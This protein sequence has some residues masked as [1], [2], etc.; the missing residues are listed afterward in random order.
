MNRN[1]HLKASTP[2][3]A[4]LAVVNRHTFTGPRDESYVYIGRG[5]PLGNNWSHVPETDAQFRVGSREEAVGRYRQWLWQEMQ[6]G[7]GPAFKA[8]ETLKERAVAG[9]KLSLACS[10]SPQLCHGDV[11]KAAIEH[12]A[13]RDREQSLRQESPSQTIFVSGSRSIKHLPAQVRDHLDRHITANSHI[14]VGDAH[15]AD[16]L[17]QQYLANAGY[18]RVT[19]FH[20][21]A[22]PRNN[23]GFQTQQVAGTRQT[24]K[25]TYMATHANRGLA[26]WDGR[27][28]GTEKN[29]GRLDT[30]VIK[31]SSPTSIR[32]EQARADI[33]ARDGQE[34]FRTIYNVPEGST[35]G[36][37]TSNLHHQDLFARDEFEHG[38]TISDSILSIPRDPDSRTHDGSN[39]RIGS[40]SHAINFVS[41]FVKDPEEARAKGER[42]YQLAERACGQ[43]TESHSRWQTF[44][45]IYDLVRKDESF[46]KGD[47]NGQYR[48]NEEKAEAINQV[49]DSIALWSNQ[50]PEPIPEPTPEEIHQYTLDLAVENKNAT[51]QPEAD[52]RIQLDTA[53]EHDP[54]LLYLH[55]LGSDSHGLATLA[56][57]T[58]FNF[59]GPQ[60]EPLVDENQVYTDV[61]ESAVFDAI[62]FSDSDHL[63]SERLS[64]GPALDA[65]FDRINLDSLPPAIPDTLSEQTEAFLLDSLIPAVDAQ[66]E[67]GFSRQE[68]LSTIYETNREIERE[69]FNDRLVNAFQVSPDAANNRQPPS[70]ED[71]L[72]A[73][74][75]LRLLVAGEYKRE[76]RGFTRD[77]IEFAKA[78]YRLDP[79][80]LRAAG[81]LKLGEYDKLINDQAAARIHWQQEHQGQPLPYRAQIARISQLEL[82][83][84]KINNRISALDPSR[85]ELVQALNCAQSNLLT[86]EQ[87]TEARLSAFSN[88]EEQQAQLSEQ[89][90]IFAQDVRSS[91]SF[92]TAQ[93][94]AAHNDH[95]RAIDEQQSVNRGNNPR[96]AYLATGRDIVT[97]EGYADLT[98]NRNNSHFGELKGEH[99]REQRAERQQL[100]KELINPDIEATQASINNE[101]AEHRHYFTQIAGREIT[102]SVEARQG[103]QPVL[104]S[105]SSVI[106]FAD[107]SR[108]RL[109]S[110]APAETNIGLDHAPIYVSLTSNENLRIPITTLPEYDALTNAVHDCRLE[111]ST[112]RTLHSPAPITG[113]D[114]EREALTTFIA[115]YIDFRQRDHVTSQL[116]RNPVFREYSQRLTDA[117]TPEELVETIALLTKENYAANQ[118]AQAHRAD[119]STPAPDKAP[120]TAKEVRELVLS[121]TPA[122]A[123]KSTRTAMREILLSTVLGKEKTDRVQ[124]LAAGKLEPS[125]GLSKLLENLESRNTE[126]ALRHFY[127]SL[128]NPNPARE[129]KFNLYEVHRL[130]P[131]FE[132]DYLYQHALAA[133][134][135]SLNGQNRSVT[136]QPEQL[137][138]DDKAISPVLV[139][140]ETN[141]YR[142][143]YG[144][145]DLREA[146]LCA[147]AVAHQRYL[148]ATKLDQSTI[149]PGFSDLEVRTVSYAVHNFDATRVS[150][151][152]VHLQASDDPHQHAL[153]DLLSLATNVN[154]TGAAQEITSEDIQLPDNYSIPTTSVISAVNFVQRDTTTLSQSTASELRQAAQKDTWKDLQ[155]SAVPDPSLLPDAPA[156]ALVQISELQ[157]TLSKAGQLQERA[158]TAFAVR[159]SH[160]NSCLERATAALRGAT[161]TST[162][163]RLPFTDPAN[164]ETTREL[165]SLALDPTR[166]DSKQLIKDHAKSFVVIQQAL[167]SGDLEKASQLSA[168]ASQARD[169]YLNVFSQIDSASNT[170]SATQHELAQNLS[171]VYELANKEFSGGAQQ[172]YTAVKENIERTVIGEQL[173]ISLANGQEIASS[174][175]SQSSVRDLLPSEIIAQATA[176]ARELAWQSFEPQ[177][178][179]DAAAGQTVDDRA[180]NLA[181]TV[182][183]HVESARSHENTLLATQEKLVTFIDERAIE[184]EDRLRTQSLTNGQ[185][186]QDRQAAERDP[187]DGPDTPPT[188]LDQTVSDQK[189]PNNPELA[190]KTQ[191]VGEQALYAQASDRDQ[192]RQQTISELKGTDSARYESLKEEVARAES[193]LTEAFLQIDATISQLELT[194]TELRVEQEIGQYRQIA[195]PVAERVNNYLKET[196][197]EEGLKSLLEPLRHEDHVER[198][199]LT[200]LQTA[201]DFN[202]PLNSSVESLQQVHEIANNLFDT[203][204]DGLERANHHLIPGMQ[205]TAETHKSEMLIGQTHRHGHQQIP[206]QNGNG[207]HPSQ[208]AAV[209]DNTHAHERILDLREMSGLSNDPL[210]DN[211]FI[212]Q[213]LTSNSPTHNL[214]Q[215]NL[216]NSSSQSNSPNSI[217]SEHDTQDLE[218]VR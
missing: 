179:R 99:E 131:Q 105:L 43:W 28:P 166:P 168:Y 24:D 44:T 7:N 138:L 165:V 126:P 162:D 31:V 182:M 148:S 158:R 11:I 175:G 103:L 156:S 80:Q 215:L 154:S 56:E 195:N 86:A 109:D 187:I 132:R 52:E 91:E 171:T 14:L 111:T 150:Q 176:E 16:S 144:Q 21:G 149:A 107:R 169:Q 130:L 178:I 12:L 72:N 84:H 152:T 181:Y 211:P 200:I 64:A 87:L 121:V 167:S 180:L 203:L 95:E 3:L 66:L 197:R 50:L 92:R 155:E 40:E 5:T 173:A 82:A 113:R 104:A 151:I 161:L 185:S 27:S 47:W 96:F 39:V 101:L 120:L 53:A 18:E 36:E 123:D 191:N 218:L 142:S 216:S 98:G 38:A 94:S 110:T 37:H 174:A 160:F 159:D 32:S 114:E 93:S 29:I 74:T 188:R 42:L 112:W 190:G 183:D 184:R 153:G 217:G 83:G 51:P 97:H 35:R 199:A 170:V 48:T 76:T 49:L 90:K 68:I 26:I 30:D 88:A 206:G 108:Q 135:A 117:R 210:K 69:R 22:T 147:Q 57:L 177:E 9:E 4:N 70:R 15:G 172:R 134:Y 77:A 189:T 73:L 75:S 137:K 106:N 205:F 62:D 8:L 71:R 23:Y 34:D 157:Q 143:Y 17:V 202:V 100:I 212:E 58:G 79:D 54:R 2:D 133:K 102:T 207:H 186:S 125:A 164:K 63:S 192:T 128:H 25:D 119:Q 46:A 65:T 124:L 145:A 41:S 163:E 6:R 118:Q 196:T 213:E 129:N 193:K 33:L 209:L 45:N 141:S 116:N 198:L 204:R 81:K 20:I 115:E 208:V 10:C 78:N 55:E 122:V 60:P 85:A 67:S 140:K 1:G 127:A 61:L 146:T 136:A 19:V 89:A 214:A 139:A 194:R 201:H 13:Q 59:D